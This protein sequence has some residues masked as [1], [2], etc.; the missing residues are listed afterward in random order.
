MPEPIP[1]AVIFGEPPA[2]AGVLLVSAELGDVVLHM[3]FQGKEFC[4]VVITR[5]DAAELVRLLEAHQR[6]E[7]HV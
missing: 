2:V 4:T 5:A 7:I 3:L 1:A 6:E